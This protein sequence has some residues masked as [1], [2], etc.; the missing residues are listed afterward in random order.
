MNTLTV[1][2]DGKEQVAQLPSTWNECS[3]R[4]AMN[5]YM[6]LAKNE[7]GIFEPHEL[8][9][10]KKKL[11]LMGLAEDERGNSVFSDKVMKAWEQDRIEEYGEE[12]GR[13]QF[14]IELGEAITLFDSFFMPLEDDEGEQ[15]LSLIHI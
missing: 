1:I 13:A 8:P 3:P 4:Q 9:F 5:A 10:M 15:I 14:L 6:L 11:L 7:L 2:I 12:D